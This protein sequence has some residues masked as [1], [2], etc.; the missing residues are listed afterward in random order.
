LI[1][2]VCA[3]ALGA[4]VGLG[5]GAL[6]AGRR[7]TLLDG[8][9]LM[10]STASIALPTFWVGLM[11]MLLFASRLG[12]LPV[13]GYGEGGTFFGLPLPGPTHL[14]LPT[15]T[16]AVFSCGYLARVTRASLIEESSQ[17]YVR[18]ARARGA[19]AASVLLRHVM[20]NSMLP[21][22]T[23]I[24]LNFAQLMGGAIATE[25][26]FNWPGLGL[27]MMSALRSRDLPVVEGG[28]IVLTA[29]FLVVNLAVD[30]S[31]ALLDPRVRD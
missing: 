26:V 31:Y 15:V 28:A 8:L 19:S 20:A 10:I 9:A 6:A 14:V 16:L 29:G 22:V 11:L 5:L 30:V 17:D 21:I 18:A 12:W 23:L 2:A 13:S 25:T 7:G 3:T 27:I 4:F 1:L 24:G